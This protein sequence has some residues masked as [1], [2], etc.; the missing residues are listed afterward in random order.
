MRPT[1]YEAISDALARRWGA[2]GR[3]GPTFWTIDRIEDV[4][5]GA[6]SD[7]PAYEIYFVGAAEPDEPQM[8]VEYVSGST[9]ASKKHARQVVQPYLDADL[10]PRHI[11]VDTNG[12]PLPRG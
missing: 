3:A 12:N 11:V 5:P 9:Y 1:W 8:V 7:G 2:S 6:G 4:A 10:P